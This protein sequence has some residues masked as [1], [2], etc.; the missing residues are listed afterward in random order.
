MTAVI[1]VNY[2]LQ[3]LDSK[4]SALAYGLYDGLSRVGWAIALCYIIFA[5]VHNYGGPVNWFLSYPLWQ[6]ASRLSYAIYL[7]HFPVIMLTMATTKTS[8]YFSELNA[9]SCFLQPIYILSIIHRTFCLQ[10]HAFF[11]NYGLSVLVA[12]IATLAFE[13]P[14]MIIEKL[15]FGSTIQP[16]RRR[17]IHEQNDSPNDRVDHNAT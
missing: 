8:D 11:G 3:Q 6:P 4:A 1:F 5:C 2:P 15:M 12:I 14:I 13:S 7:V 16:E 17:N 9:V 10:Y